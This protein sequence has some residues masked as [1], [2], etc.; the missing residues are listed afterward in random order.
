MKKML[1]QYK[2]VILYLFFGVCTT[3]VNVGTYWLMAYPLHLRVMPSTVVAWLT[4]VLFAYFTNRKWVFHSD[5]SDFT[6]VV[7][8]LISFFGCRLATGAID[9]G[10]MYMFADILEWNDVAIKFASNVFVII[11]NYVASKWLIFKKEHR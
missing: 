3:A 1:L 4:A 2:D 5:A 10:C 9:W 6:A 8:E 7:K 11:L